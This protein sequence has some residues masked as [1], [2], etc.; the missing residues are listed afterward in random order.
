MRLSPTH[1]SCAGGR[2]PA[3]LPQPRQAHELRSLG[4]LSLYLLVICKTANFMNCNFIKQEAVTAPTTQLQGAGWP[5]LIPISRAGNSS[6]AG[7]HR[8]R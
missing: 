7:S 4:R 5:G 3:P 1:F 2:E 6:S 8:P